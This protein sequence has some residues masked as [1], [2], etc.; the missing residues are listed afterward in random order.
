M[1]NRTRV[2]RDRLEVSV[3]WVWRCS[4]GTSC[5]HSTADHEEFNLQR[6]VL[7]FPPILV[8]PNQ[9]LCVKLVASGVNTI[10]LQEP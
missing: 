1:W 2:V 6:G 3:R 5:P 8:W 4:R 9:T 10:H 7:I